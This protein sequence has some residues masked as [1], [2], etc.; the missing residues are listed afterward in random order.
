[1]VS[2]LRK[3]S[4]HNFSLAILYHSMPSRFFVILC[5]HHA[6]LNHSLTLLFFTIPL[7]INNTQCQR[8]SFHIISGALLF[9]SSPSL[10]LSTP[11]RCNS[12][13]V[14]AFPRRNH[15]FLFHCLSSRVVTLPLLF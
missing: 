14:L 2:P 5:R 6:S 10:F 1:M 3:F 15:A 4:L 9:S 12:Q 7:L 13:H 8:K 11:F